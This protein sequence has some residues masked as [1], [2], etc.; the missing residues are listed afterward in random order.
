MTKHNFEAE[1][2]KILELLTH[3]IYSNKEI[4][5]R[6]LISNASDAI[7]KARLKA[8][9]DTT[10]LWE[11]H[12]FEI[13][14]KADKEKNIIE[15][16]DNGIWMTKEEVH[17]NIWTI[18]KS[19]TKDF[20]EKLKKA[21]ETEDHNLIGQF[22]VGFYSAFMVADKVEIETKSPLDKKAH[23]WTSDWK[24]NYEI[25]ESDKKTRWT[26][27][28]LFIDE[29]NKEL[30]EEW[31][32]R[33]L[34]KKYSNYVW[35]P[36][37]LEEEKKEE[38]KDGEPW[39]VIWKE[40][41]RVNETTAIWKKSKSSVKK[42]EYIEFYK[43]VSMDF[44]EP[45]SHI[46]N[47]VEWKVSY[48][49][50]LYIP[51]EKN[52]FV[53]MDD[54]S[55]E[56][57]PK[58]YVQNVLILENA[59]ELLPVWLRFVSWVVETSDLPLNISREMLQSNMV[60]DTIKKSLVKKVVAELKKVMKN[61]S[62]TYDKFYENYKLMLK[63]GTYYEWDMKE[64]IASLLKFKSTI[65]TKNISFDEYIEKS[66]DKECCKEDWE[67][68]TWKKEWHNHKE[69]ESCCWGG[70]H[71]WEWKVWKTIYYISWKTE[72]A[73]LSSP[74]LTQFRENNVNV[75][76][77]IDP[78]DEWILQALSEYK[79]NKLV[80]ISA[81]DINLKEESK[82]ELEEKEKLW[83]EYKDILEFV[84]NTISADKIE[85]VELNE[86][87]WDAVSALKTPTNGMNP[88]MEKM[89]KAMWQPVP[90]QKRI[91]ELNP[92]SD[93]VKSMKWEFTNNIKSEKL[94]D[95][96]IY[97]YNQAV[98]LEWWELENVWEFVKLVNKF[99]WEYLK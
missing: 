27:L 19:G 11:D 84:K 22:G 5:L 95:M 72:G 89:M 75:L 28:R 32:I 98:L 97:S 30:V 44:N 7:D 78:I 69:W 4:F 83:E 66:E 51:K 18:A 9:T 46:H 34:I 12:N 88:Q 63:E 16:E 59:K 20:L 17:S 8:L 49:S 68:N 64:D 31:K 25:S 10:F 24:S 53:N 1:T 13:K 50:L 42:E 40:F 67:K 77:F 70:C 79:W 35:V 52:M 14:I 54:P 92:K 39:K 71:E 23:K 74:Y 60:L 57:G 41:V 21:K 48:K 65:E 81:S 6:E 33:E 37:M 62:D 85:K 94:N 26:I 76:L 87:L 55:K 80:N 61:D 29:S 15:I 99:A 90:P 38:W 43:T 73:V 93:I 96:I 82:E 56:Y 3:S 45:L 58:L 2:W 47:N 36:I 86:K 91:L